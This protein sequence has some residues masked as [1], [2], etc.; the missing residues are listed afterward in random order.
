MADVNF[1]NLPM[2]KAGQT[3]TKKATVVSEDS[4]EQ[5]D[6]QTSG[7][8]VLFNPLLA[9]MIA[10]QP[11]QTSKGIGIQADAAASLSFDSSD[12]DPEKGHGV[13]NLFGSAIAVASSATGILFGQPTTNI[14]SDPQD[15]ANSAS[16]EKII[17]KESTTFS[18]RQTRFAQALGVDTNGV[19]LKLVNSSAQSEQSST[20]SKDF[21][22]NMMTMGEIIP[23]KEALNQALTDNNAIEAA[24]RRSRNIP[25][26]HNAAD[27]ST[28]AASIIQKKIDSSPASQ[29]QNVTTA[30]TVIQLQKGV[31]A[32]HGSRT[33]DG[34]TNKKTTVQAVSA[35]TDPSTLTDMGASLK[36]AESQTKQDHGQ[37][38]TQRDS[39]EP[40][41]QQ[42]PG[43]VVAKE[44]LD[45][46]KP[47][48][49]LLDLQAGGHTAAAN[50][51]SLKLPVIAPEIAASV[52]DQIANGVSLKILN[53]VSEMR[54]ALK[55]ESLG[56]VVVSVRMEDN[57]MVARID[58]S[59]QSVKTM[60][61]GNMAQLRDLLVNRGVQV[62]RID[63]LNASTTS[64]SESNNHPQQKSKNSSKR[65]INEAAESLEPMHQLGYNTLDYLI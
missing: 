5:Q 6:D 37:N 4:K 16:K 38:P 21:T 32:V 27:P 8:N 62:D 15:D 50:T 44:R 33:Q 43:V 24:V 11:P 22:D 18:A 61:D 25:G 13:V 40:K 42:S 23:K 65:T 26:T 10:L 17:G 48:D 36:H 14:A 28:L 60:L 19:D 46:V 52:R 45:V 47:T 54:V 30:G 2:Q 58:V 3:T 41:L 29:N 1:I 49:A 39:I 53:N 20:V 59:H 7:Q 56:E 57:A 31:T 63:V 55:P 9:Q 64:F 34:D 35:K 12:S 51:I